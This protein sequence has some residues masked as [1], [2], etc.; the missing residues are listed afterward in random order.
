[1]AYTVRNTKP[2]ISVSAI[3]VGINVAVFVLQM[4]SG[5]LDVLLYEKGVLDTELVLQGG[6]Y[7]RLVTS[8]FLHADIS[9]LAS[10]MIILYFLGNMIERRF[11]SLSYLLMYLSSGVIG[12][13]SS[14]MMQQRSGEL[15]R[16][17]GAS[18]AV[19]G[20]V[21]AY[22]ALAVL[23]RRYL[24][25]GERNRI[26]F[27]VFYSLFIGFQSSGIDNAAHVGGFAAGFVIA[28]LILLSGKR[29]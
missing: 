5:R 21:G 27:G 3:L 6:E 29:K 20:I 26:L 13:L 23:N 16:S 18:G 17:L 24:S 25:S 8:M 1:M 11:G 12:D 19:F 7:Y 9:H 15:H 22:L 14:M 4:L 10:N 2:D 28:N